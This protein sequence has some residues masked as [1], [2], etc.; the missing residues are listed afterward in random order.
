MRTAWAALQLNCFL[1]TLMI[2]CLLLSR[3]WG[4]ERQEQLTF[5]DPRSLGQ[6][7]VARPDHVAGL[8]WNVAI[9]RVELAPMYRVIA[10]TFDLCE[11]A[12]EHAGYDEILLRKVVR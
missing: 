8:P 4:E 2:C 6:F 11:A 5:P 7:W 3:G 9:R 10:L 1:A 12:G